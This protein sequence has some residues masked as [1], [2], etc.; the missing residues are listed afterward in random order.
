[1]TAVSCSS[2][3]ARAATDTGPVHVDL[4]APR[5]SD[6]PHGSSLEV[7]VVAAS[8]VSDSAG[9]T[10]HGRAARHRSPPDGNVPC[11]EHRLGRRAD[12]V[13]GC[14]RCRVHQ[15]GRSRVDLRGMAVDPSGT[16]RSMFSGAVSIDQESS[17]LS[18]NVT[19]ADGRALVER[20][21]DPGFELE[22]FVSRRRRRH[23]PAPTPAGSDRAAEPPRSVGARPVVQGRHS[24]DTAR[25]SVGPPEWPSR[26]SGR[27]PC[28]AS[29]ARSDHRRRRSPRPAPPRPWRRRAGVE[30]D[31]PLHAAAMFVDSFGRPTA[32]VSARPIAS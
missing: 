29:A 5:T 3:A 32:G 30:G 21:V 24:E 1:M 22:P 31:R 10:S 20:S 6:D 28:R 15:Q 17:G 2:S 19:L 23:R 14:S 18:S 27:R 25:C 11:D 8:I 12:A 7:V 26:V 13:R 16:P 9:W 4:P